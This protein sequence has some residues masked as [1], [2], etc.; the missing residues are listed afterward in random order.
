MME[1]STDVSSSISLN[2][3]EILLDEDSCDDDLEASEGPS[4][5][6]SCNTS[7]IFSDIRILPDSMVVSPNDTL[8]IVENE[9]EKSSNGNQAAEQSPGVK[10]LKR[11]SDENKEGTVGPKKIKRRNQAI[12]ASKDEDETLDENP[13]S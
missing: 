6:F 2:P 12:Y 7:E 4:S 5:D 10:P 9:L 13:F 11:L 8:D 1:S 3:D